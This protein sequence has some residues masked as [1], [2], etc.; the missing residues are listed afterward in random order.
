MDEN[1][2]NGNAF[3]RAQNATFSKARSR[4][5]ADSLE[6]RS[7]NTICEEAR[8]PNRNHCWSRGTATF[9]VMAKSA[10]ALAPSALLPVEFQEHSIRKNPE[11]WRKPP[12]SWGFAMW[13]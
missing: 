9:L 5:T 8:C 13:L 4:D 2:G 1:A 10:R 3:P 7:L 6:S 11:K 12:S